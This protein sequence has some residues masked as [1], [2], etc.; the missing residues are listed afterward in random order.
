MLIEQFL[1]IPTKI[2]CT[3]F[4]HICFFLKKDP[5]IQ[6]FEEKY[7]IKYENKRMEQDAAKNLENAE[8]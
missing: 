1:K 6:E 5:T 4:Y 7:G 8:K 3:L 2:T